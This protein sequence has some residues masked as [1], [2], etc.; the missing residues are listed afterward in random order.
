MTAF[1][2]GI[3][4]VTAGGSG[5]GRNADPFEL[6]HGALPRLGS[7]IPFVSQRFR[8]L[9]R[10]DKFSMLGLR[11]VAYALRDAGLDEWEQRRE[12]GV[13]ASTVF[14]CLATDVDFYNT[15]L[16]Q[17]G[18]LAD[19]N[20]FAHTLPNTFLGHASIVFGLTGPNYVIN[21]KTDSGLTALVSALEC[22][23]AGEADFMLAGI[24][25]IEHPTGFEE[26]DAV[27][28]SVF[29]VLEKT[30]RKDCKSHGRLSM[31]KGGRLFFTDVE[32]KDIS[33][34]VKK[35]HIVEL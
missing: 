19:P 31:D 33:G 21:D 22:I 23:S 7:R 34:V 11:A 20:L 6:S 35:I 26:T 17:N 14:G 4:W 29:V 2:T 30:L 25:D 8:R 5:M 10:L 3:G 32:I 13:I 28:G 12:I 15:V 24:C 16:P 27:P 9:G 18:L 1:I